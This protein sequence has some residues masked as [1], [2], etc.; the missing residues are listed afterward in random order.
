MS[1]RYLRYLKFWINLTN[2]L[3]LRYLKSHLILKCL[4]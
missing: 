4:R 1:L 2:L 3:S